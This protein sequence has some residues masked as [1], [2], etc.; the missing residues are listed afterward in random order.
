LARPSGSIDLSPAWSLASAAG[1]LD[2]LMR[3]LPTTMLESLLK[4]ERDVLSGRRPGLT[5]RPT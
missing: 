5:P 1:D 4:L 2:K 3:S